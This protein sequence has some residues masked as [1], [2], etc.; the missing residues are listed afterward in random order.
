MTW[1]K[2]LISSISGSDDDN[3]NDDTNKLLNTLYAFSH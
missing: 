3:D 1:L 2:L